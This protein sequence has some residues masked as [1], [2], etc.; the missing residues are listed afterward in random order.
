MT[1]EEVQKR[2]D[3]GEM[4]EDIDILKLKREDGYCIAHQQVFRGWV[5][6]DKEALKIYDPTG[7]S[8]AHWMANNC[9]RLVQTHGKEYSVKGIIE[10]PEILAL[11]TKDVFKTTVAYLQLNRGWEP[12]TEEAKAYVLA[13]RLK[14]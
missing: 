9:S 12:Q 13:E 2:V 3:R 5:T 8:I 4:F 10:D 1:Y 11:E 14:E 6:E 7:W